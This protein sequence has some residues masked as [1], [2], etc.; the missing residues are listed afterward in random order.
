[1]TQGRHPISDAKRVS[2]REHSLALEP[3]PGVLADTPPPDWLPGLAKETWRI[4]LP[5]L[6]QGAFAPIDLAILET[7]CETYAHYRIAVAAV[8]AEGQTLLD[9]KGKQY[10]H[11]CCAQAQRAADALRKIGSSLGIS[12]KARMVI[13]VP[14]KPTAAKTSLAAFREDV[15]E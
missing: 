4:L 3:R 12:P 8:Q 1:M 2:T 10:T 6:C 14:P 15:A 7:Y 11:P 9:A 13:K 5:Q